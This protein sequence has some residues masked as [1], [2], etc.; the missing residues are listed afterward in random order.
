MGTRSPQVGWEGALAN[1]GGN[2]LVGDVFPPKFAVALFHPN[3]WGLNPG[4]VAGLARRAV[5][6]F[7]LIEGVIMANF[8]IYCQSYRGRHYR[9]FSDFCGPKSS[10]TFR[11]FY[12]DTPIYIYIYYIYIYI[13]RE[14]NININIWKHRNTEI[15]KYRNIYIYIYI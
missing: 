8:R 12:N 7:N 1:L 2:T 10:K 15:S 11:N 5:A 14:R 9:E 3:L 13:H 4:T 6:Y